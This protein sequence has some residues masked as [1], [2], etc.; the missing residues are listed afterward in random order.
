MIEML[1]LITIIVLALASPAQRNLPVQ[2]EP[3]VEDGAVHELFLPMLALPESVIGAD[4]KP[5]YGYATPHRRV[6]DVPFY[7]WGAYPMYCANANYWPMVRRKPA[8]TT[9]GC[10]DGQ[11]TLMLFNEPELGHFP[12]TPTEAAQFTHGVVWS[13]P[14]V[15][16]GN[17]YGD[18]GGILTGLAWFR[19][20]IAQYAVRYDE[21]PPLAGVHLHVY[22]VGDLDLDALQEW[23]AIAE[24]YGWYIVVSE[25]GTFPTPD[26]LPA[27]VAERL[28]AFLSVV[29][30]TLRPEYLFWFSDY[31]QPWALGGS[32][33]WHHFNLTEIDA[34]PTVVGD[35]WFV[36]IR[37]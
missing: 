29:E 34:S 13:G 16:C 3:K 8:E 17:F 31:L 20:Y 25:S 6:Y 22:E 1:K 11:R 19:E 21:A 9:A 15:C 10:D 5:I 27:D 18:G 33:A 23:R 36:W 14:V 24:Q 32:T 12:A 4:A 28:P 30:D 35:A 37:R 7:N 2:P 26:Y